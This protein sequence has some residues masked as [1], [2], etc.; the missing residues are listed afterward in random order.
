MRIWN[1]GNSLQW[2]TSVGCWQTAA[3]EMIILLQIRLQFAAPAAVTI[4]SNGFIH[5]FFPWASPLINWFVLISTPSLLVLLVWRNEVSASAV[6]RKCPEDPV[7][8]VC[9]WCGQ[10]KSLM[11]ITTNWEG[12]ISEIIVCFDLPFKDV[13]ESKNDATSLSKRCK[14][15]DYFFNGSDTNKNIRAVFQNRRINETSSKI[16]SVKAVSENQNVWPLM[17]KTQLYMVSPSNFVLSRYFFRKES[18]H[19][20][21]WRYE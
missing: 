13:G 12:D 3:N 15:F 2:D 9:W 16:T 18:N 5:Q 6:H 11:N 4:F 19:L 21:S 10:W 8:Y 1:I 7:T 14:K 17:Q 20:Y